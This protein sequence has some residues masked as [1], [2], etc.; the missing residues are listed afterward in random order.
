MNR[1]ARAML[2][3][4][5]L[6][7]SDPPAADFAA[8]VTPPPRAQFVASPRGALTLEA[9]FR[10]VQVIQTAASQLTLHAYR[11]GLRLDSASEP[12]LIKSPAPDVPMEDLISETV[13]ALALQGNAYLRILRDREGRAIGARP[14]NP[15][16]CQPILKG[17]DQTRLTVWRGREWDTNQI[18]HLRL[19]RVPG[20]PEGLGPIQACVRS[21][22]GAAA[23]ADY[24]RAFT[25]ASGLPT[26]ILSTDQ[27]ITPEQAEQAKARWNEHN[28]GTGV[29]V[30]GSGLKFSA[31]ALKPSEVQFLES[32]AFDTLAIGRMFGVPAHMLLASMEGT[33]MTYANVQDAALDFVRWSLMAYL[34]PIETALSQVLP[35]GT[36]A[37]FNLDA[38][39]RADTASRMAAHATAIS[40][41]I[42]APSYARQIEG[43][44]ET[45][46]PT[47]TTETEEN[48]Q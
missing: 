47:T 14:L 48:H 3:A 44:P 42:Y 18:K 20:E 2:R 13:A 15:D 35:R 38:L 5:I 26:G 27:H 40:A 7:R 22:N 37:R 4:G 28:S 29:A 23:M 43:I 16:D 21:L 32:R 45:A 11:D 19:L 46:A 41:G 17:Q 12:S 31:L 24:A 30:I 8:N 34:R 6:T 1:L 39:L 36:T 10:S 25:Q 33:S 9:V